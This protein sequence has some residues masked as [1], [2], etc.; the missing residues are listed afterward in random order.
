M[1][2]GVFG[3]GLRG[4]GFRMD[5]PQKG[6]EGRRRLSRVAGLERSLR[7]TRGPFD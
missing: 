1:I 3:K 5:G 7:H 2:K 6:P 4:C